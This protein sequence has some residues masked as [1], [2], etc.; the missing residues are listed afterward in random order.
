[1][2]NIDRALKNERLLRALTGMNRQAFDEL[3]CVFNDVYQEA[4]LSDVRPRQRA[5]GGGRKAR[6]E[7]T[8]AKLFFILF[9][10]KCY[11]T[12]D[13]LG[14]LFDLERGRSNRWVHRL[15]ETLEAALGRKM[16]LPERKLESIE[17]FLERFPDVKEITIDGTERPVQRPQ[18][19]EKQKDHYSGKKKRH[20]RKH[21]TGTT[22]KKRVVLLTKARAGKVHDKRQLD[23]EELVEN[24]P[25]EVAIEGDL[26]FQGLQKE[27]ANIHLPHKKPKGKELSE[28]QKQENKEFSSRRVVCEHAHA[29]IKRYGAV[30]AIYRNRVPDFDDRLMLTATG[31]WNFYLEAA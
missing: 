9:Y 31:L 29:G 26:G 21:I 16:V 5:R 22:R 14:L 6:L 10:Y 3:C 11:P 13:V 28:E 19:E 2:L 12:F 25:T 20:T 8:E 1:M 15:Q 4:I 7:N 18:D 23:E 17:Q 27:F 24:I 30:S